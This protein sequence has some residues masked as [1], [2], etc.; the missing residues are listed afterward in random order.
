MN[1]SPVIETPQEVEPKTM[2]FTE[3][4]EEIINGK[5]VTKLEWENK[6]IFCLLKSGLL[7]IHNEK[8]FHSWI[9]SEEDMAGTDWVIRA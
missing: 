4:I 9:V 2:T 7:T 1:S 8:G 6:E 3:A 5:V